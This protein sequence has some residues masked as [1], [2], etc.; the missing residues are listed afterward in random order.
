MTKAYV[1]VL[2]LLAAASGCASSGKPSLGDG[3]PARAA[4][5]NLTESF[6]EFRASQVKS[7]SYD[8]SFKVKKGATSYD[9]IAVVN[10]ELTRTN[11]PLTLDFV[12]KTITRI[13]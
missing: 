7:V 11:A 10:A 4:Q 9:G 6:A 2:A 5:D 8:L 1:L 13:E 12:G 3:I